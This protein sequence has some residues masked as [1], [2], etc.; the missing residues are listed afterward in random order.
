LRECAQDFNNSPICDLGCGNRS[1][2]NQVHNLGY[3]VIGINPYKEG[4]EIASNGN[5]DIE[6]VTGD[7]K[8]LNNLY[9]NHKLV[10]LLK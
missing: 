4:I 3:K 8:T 10:F 7:S 5:Q 6:F 9:G 2:T 1:A